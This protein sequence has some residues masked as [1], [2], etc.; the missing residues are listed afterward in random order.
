MKTDTI[1][2]T[3]T[4]ASKHDRD[5]RIPVVV[6]RIAQHRRLQGL[7]NSLLPAF[8]S[9]AFEQVNCYSFIFQSVPY[10]AQ[11]GRN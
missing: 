9:S 2:K 1:R 6:K 11:L 7:V 10:V 4:V 8:H 3:S 5:A